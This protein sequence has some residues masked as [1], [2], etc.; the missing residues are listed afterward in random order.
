MASSPSKTFSLKRKGREEDND[1]HKIPCKYGKDCY[2][3]NEAHLQE[4]SHS[5]DTTTPGKKQKMHLESSSFYFSND[6]PILFT[7][8]KGIDD[9]YNQCTIAVDIEGILA[10]NC[11]NL[12][13]SVQ[14]NYMF[15]VPWLIS[16]YPKCVRDKPLL[17]VHGFTRSEKLGIEA[18]AMK[19]TNI[20][21]VHA[22]LPI[23]YGTHH[24]K[25]MFLL[26][27]NGFKVVIHTANLIESDWFQKT[28]G[29]WISPMYV[30]K[31]SSYCEQNDTFKKDLVDYLISYKSSKL[32]KWVTNITDYDMTS[33]KV[34]LIASIPGRHLGMSSMNKWGHL[35]LRKVLSEHG[36]DKSLVTKEWPVVGQF[37]SIGS[38][39][40]DDK[41]WLSSEWLRSLS[42]CKDE[43]FIHGLGKSGNLL[44]LIYPTIKNVKDSLEGYSAGGSLPYGVKLAMKQR[45]LKEYLCQWV[46][47]NV[48]RSLASPH[49]K[50]YTRISPDSKSSPWF[51]LTSANLSKAAWGV[52]EK[53]QSQLMIR[54]YEIGVLFIPEVDADRN[55]PLYNLEPN[56]TKAK[57]K[58]LQLPYDVPLIPYA[59]TD[60][61][62][63]WDI[64]Y[65]TE[66]SHGRLWIPS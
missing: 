30:K 65:T 54:S 7:T 13:E 4:F 9:K 34:H 57:Q 29:I 48:G 14:F 60:K 25:M 35:K 5:K 46:A 16:K 28:Q 3:K 56:I 18:E 31:A 21:L 63:V 26:Y 55:Q 53:D 32:S 12:E 42:C 24:T 52:Y 11:E 6:N 23:P 58:S 17:L 61:P 8:V 66:D 1:I 2:R 37:S 64:K 47:N 62:W 44:K 19:Y 43:K 20:D 50:S 39:G 59:S 15:D 41:K 45:Y 10:E 27:S 33:A 22:K 40:D 51:L 36:P 38:L 49:I